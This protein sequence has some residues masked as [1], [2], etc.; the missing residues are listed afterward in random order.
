LCVVSHDQPGLLASITAAIT[1]AGLEI[2]A[3]QIHSRFLPNGS[4]QA[5]DLFWVRSARG[6]SG[7][8]D[9][10]PRLESDLEQVIT[11]RV[12]AADLL[13][14]DTLAPPRAHVSVDVQIDRQRAARHT[15]IELSAE[16]RAGLLFTVA[17]TLHELGVSVAIAKI[18]TEHGRAADVFYVNEFDGTK[19]SAGERTRAVRERLLEVLRPP[20]PP[21][22]AAS[23][24]RA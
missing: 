9:V 24:R 11:G 18:H 13:K 12:A 20:P 7:V 23:A 21:P 5:V 4:V 1:A 15:V 14:R 16:D 19:L 10:F 22:R 6:P 2:H 17:Q 8:A 3:A